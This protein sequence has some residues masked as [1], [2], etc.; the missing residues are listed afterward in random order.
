MAALVGAASTQDRDGVAPLLARDTGSKT[1]HL[2]LD[3]AYEGRGVRAVRE[4]GWTAEVVRRS[5]ER[6]HG[7]W[8]HPPMPHF[9]ARRGF[10]L[11]RRRWVVE[12]TFAW[13]G[14]NRR[15]SKDYE[16]RTDVSEA[17]IWVAMMRLLVRRLAYP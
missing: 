17:M 7:Q 12:R 4:R 11:V 14:R 15:L 16:A 6:G 1:R 13:L 2:W 10:E 8:R 9:T 3:S 5:G